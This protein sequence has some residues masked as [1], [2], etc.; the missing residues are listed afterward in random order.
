MFKIFNRRIKPNNKRTNKYLDK[1]KKVYLVGVWARSGIM[2]C[3]FAGR[4]TK[5]GEPLVWEYYDCNG[6]CDEWH[7]MPIHNI[8]SGTVLKW[9]FDKKEAQLIADIYNHLHSL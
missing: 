5:D 6:A 3:F 9:T 1:L 8:T 4:Y 7:L 2:E